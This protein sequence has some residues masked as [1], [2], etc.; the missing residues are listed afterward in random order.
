MTTIDPRA[1][2][3]V[4]VY[5]F[6]AP[7]PRPRYL[8]QPAQRGE[9]V[10]VQLA[11]P[12][13]SRVPR[14]PDEVDWPQ[15]FDGGNGVTGWFDAWM[16]V[17]IDLTFDREKLIDDFIA[18]LWPFRFV[19]VRPVAWWHDLGYHLGYLVPWDTP[20]ATLKTLVPRPRTERNAIQRRALDRH[21]R[22]GLLYL[23]LPRWRARAAWKVVRALGGPRYYGG[24]PEPETDDG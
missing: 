14:I 16:T 11:K 5:D 10:Q 20:G 24:G 3:A 4:D 18:A 15:T 1:S 7:V 19:D 12:T 22:V 8:V 6:V 2:L 23:G 21:F 13:W 9:P 17:N